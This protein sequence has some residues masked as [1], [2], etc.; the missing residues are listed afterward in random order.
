MSDE[1]PTEPVVEQPQPVTEPAAP[2]ATARR[3]FRERFRAARQPDANRAY[4]LGALI[5]SALAGVIV[6]GLGGMA[7]HAAVDDDGPDR[8]DFRHG[9]GPWDR[10]FGERPGPPRD[11]YREAPPVP[12]GEAPPTTTP[13]DED[14]S[15]SESPSDQS[16][17]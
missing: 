15:P 10:D 14:S 16:S 9:P 13:D 4:S 1:T 17:S 6:G 3:G 7:L 11:F 2:A 8:G 5:A 12:P